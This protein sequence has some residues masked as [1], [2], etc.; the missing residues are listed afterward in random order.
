MAN[1]HVQPGKVLDYVNTSGAA[2]AAGDVVVAGALLAVALCDIAPGSSGAA[3][4]D[5][6]WALPKVAGTAIA[7]GSA[8]MWDASA[9]AFT[10]AGGAAAT[11]DVTGNGAVAFDAAS[12]ATTVLHVKLTGVPGTVTA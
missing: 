2:V 12:S 3:A 5:G 9:S 6:V 11:G 10:A 7:Q 1:N 4:I 8:L